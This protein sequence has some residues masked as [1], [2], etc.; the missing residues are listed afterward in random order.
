MQNEYTQNRYLYNAKELQ[1]DFG[2]DWY[3]Y[4][5]RFYD[6]QIGR[7]HVVDPHA[8]NY[9]HASPYAYVENNPISRIDPDG[10]DWDIVIDHEKQNIIIAANFNTISGNINTMQTSAED[11][12]NQSGKFNYVIGK[13]DEAVSYSINFEISVQ[14]PGNAADN[15][16]SVLDDNATVFSERTR[17]D[18][19]GNKVT[20]EGLADGQNIAVKESNSQNS[21]IMS[22][23]MGHNLGMSDSRGIMRTVGGQSLQRRSVRE[24]LG[25]SGIGRGVRG[26]ATNAEMQSRTVIGTEPSDF[27]NGKIR[28]NNEWDKKNF[29]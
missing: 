23:E 11:W 13:G 16:V 5:A 27:Q 25:H 26:A 4:G 22:H 2:L 3:D 21:Q 24:T 20:A 29:R 14:N 1:D 6:A 12:N 8:E 15:M 7:W 19:D 28:R 9:F 18:S 10:R 17:I